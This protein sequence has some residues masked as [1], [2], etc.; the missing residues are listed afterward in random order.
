MTLRDDMA[1]MASWQ[2]RLLEQ[3]QNL[4]AD[5][6]RLA[7]HGPTD[8]DASAHTVVDMGLTRWRAGLS[9]RLH[10]R[11]ELE[12][13]AYVVGVP[14]RLVDTAR[15]HGLAGIHWND[16]E[17][18]RL[19]RTGGRSASR[20]GALE[21]IR[22][23]V[24]QLQR[25]AMLAAATPTSWHAGEVG[26]TDQLTRNMQGRWRLAEALG[27]VASTSAPEHA[28]LWDDTRW[29]WQRLAETTVSGSTALDLHIELVAAA[30]PSVEELADHALSLL[31]RRAQLHGR[32]GRWADAPQFLIAD[33]SA[34]ITT[35][36]D[37]GPQWAATRAAIDL[38]TTSSEP[39][40]EWQERDADSS[41]AQQGP[42]F[43]PDTEPDFR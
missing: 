8:H 22:E 42:Y 18:V 1:D 21:R 6:R 15:E 34:A 43:G 37:P 10:E 5:Y 11:R 38:I 7:L 2:T 16:G 9:D 30:R 41:A 20:D 35:L 36:A 25:S 28:R 23:Q 3:I 33:A 40:Q 14:P 19:S 4:A 12:A 17:L 39:S 24:Y 13:Q 29:R 32:S 26:V 31:E 27:F